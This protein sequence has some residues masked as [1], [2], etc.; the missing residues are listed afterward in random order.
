ML[1]AV[2]RGNP[3]H[4]SAQPEGL[5]LATGDR[6]LPGRV[7]ALPDNWA[8]CFRAGA[9]GLIHHQAIALEPA[10]ESWSFSAGGAYRG[11]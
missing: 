9:D 2:R 5:Y 7:R 1:V 11:G 3:L 8:G 4:W 6:G 10:A